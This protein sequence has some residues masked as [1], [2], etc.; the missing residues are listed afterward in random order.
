M[1]ACVKCAFA[2][3]TFYLLNVQKLQH[4]KKNAHT[5][6]FMH[7]HNNF[8]SL[9]LKNNLKIRKKERKK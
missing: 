3:S 7:E 5:H 8:F 4:I 2:I 6:T 9:N 1:C